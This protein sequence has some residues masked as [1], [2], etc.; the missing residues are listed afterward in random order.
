M[1]N[2]TE[3]NCPI[4]KIELVNHNSDMMVDNM[5][6]CKNCNNYYTQEYLKDRL[7]TKKTPETILLDNEFNRGFKSGYLQAIMRFSVLNSDSI[8]K[9]LQEFDTMEFFK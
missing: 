4:C 7:N 3:M 8:V 9:A 2:I 6:Y 1:T 5:L